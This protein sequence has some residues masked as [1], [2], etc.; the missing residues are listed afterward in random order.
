MGKNVLV[1]QELNLEIQHH[2]QACYALHQ[3]G[4]AVSIGFKT[5]FEVESAVSTHSIQVHTPVPPIYYV[6]IQFPLVFL[7]K[8][9]FQSDSHLN[10]PTLT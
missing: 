10:T 1:W 5:S 7:F 9:T 6:I 4:L 8:I 2:S 3:L